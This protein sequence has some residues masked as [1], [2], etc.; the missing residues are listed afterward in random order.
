MVVATMDS[1]PPS[2]A[3]AREGVVVGN[4]RTRADFA[5]LPAAEA[6]AAPPPTREALTEAV[7]RANT[8]LRA[9]TRSVEFEYDADL[10][11]TVVRLVD[12]ESPQVL[13]QVP[14]PEMLDITRALER[15]QLSLLHD[16]A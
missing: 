14:S 4:E 3:T 1:L 9:Y 15:M 16:E 7:E 13:R 2:P 8:V 6:A 5:P 10:G 12:T 11:L